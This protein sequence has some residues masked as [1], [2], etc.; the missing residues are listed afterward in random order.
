MLPANAQEPATLAGPKIRLTISGTGASAREKVQILDGQVWIDALDT[1]G[2]TVVLGGASSGGGCRIT[3]IQT[4]DPR[5]VVRGECA[6]GTYERQLQLGPDADL[7]SVMVQYTTKS[8]KPVSSVEDRL[9]FAPETRDVDTPSQGPLDFVWSQNIK[10]SQDQLDAHWAYKSPAVQ[11]Q[12]GRVFAAIFPRLDLLTAARL[13]AE[14]TALDLA[15]MPKGHAWFSY[16]AVSG[17]PTGHSYFQRTSDTPLSA[18]SGPIAYHYWILASA[19]PDRLGYRRVTQL[20]WE[21][22]GHPTLLGSL[23][24]QRNLK[25]P[26]LFLFDEWRHEAWTRYADEKYWESDCG[27]KKCGALTSNRNP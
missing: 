23:D 11:F 13:R 3:S 12:Q 6:D 10:A 21:K 5:I 24:L 8:G 1:S 22:F 25:R 4:T 19:Q 2:P 26:E 15:V 27:G 20:M 9:T 14:P 16:G 17:K 18:T 7:I